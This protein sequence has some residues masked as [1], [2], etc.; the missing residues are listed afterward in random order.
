MYVLNY[1]AFS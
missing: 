1:K